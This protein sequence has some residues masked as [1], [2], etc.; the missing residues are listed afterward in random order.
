MTL[1]MPGPLL[2]MKKSP[3]KDD[4]VETPAERDQAEDPV[5]DDDFEV[6]ENETA[7][8]E[9][10]TGYCTPRSCSS[11]MI[12]PADPAVEQANS[13]PDQPDAAPTEPVTEVGKE[14]SGESEEC[15]AATTPDKSVV[16]SEVMVSAITAEAGPIT[17]EAEAV[18]SQE[19]A[20]VDVAKEEETITP[21]MD[22]HESK[23][24]PP[25]NVVSL[26]EPEENKHNE[27]SSQEVMD[28]DDQ[29]SG[30]TKEVLPEVKS[31]STKPAKKSSLMSFLWI[32]MLMF[33]VWSVT[34]PIC[35]MR[36]GKDAQQSMS[37]LVHFYK[38]VSSKVFGSVAT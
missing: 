6:S 31:M 13:E 18:A 15:P 19:P 37:C 35:T 28:E 2:K 8:E 24:A 21:T 17:E 3:G 29:P 14:V 1:G 23:A 12:E 4:K 9:A 22:E 20:V 27:V 30:V 10:V 32:L 38:R 34:F 26:P 25:R 11:A 5:E 16:V 33:A 36:G 7:T